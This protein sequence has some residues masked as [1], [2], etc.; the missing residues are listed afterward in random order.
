M[1]RLP[2]FFVARLFKL[3]QKTAIRDPRSR[4]RIRRVEFHII[5]QADAE[6][7]RTPPCPAPET[8]P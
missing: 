1:P 3:G 7:D 8:A 6:P 4:E 2:F 5:R